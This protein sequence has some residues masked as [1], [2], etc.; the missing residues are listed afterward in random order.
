LTQENLNISY[1]VD[2][3]SSLVY[4]VQFFTDFILARPATPA[5]Y[6]HIERLTPTEFYGRFEEFFGNPDEVRAF[7]KIGKPTPF[8]A[9]TVN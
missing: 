7:A 9:E 3:K 1:F 5:L 8:T 2:S 4:E 6:S